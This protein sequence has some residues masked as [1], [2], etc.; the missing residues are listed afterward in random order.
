MWE[1]LN[2][3]TYGCKRID[4]EAYTRPD[5]EYSHHFHE[6]H[7]R[8]IDKIEQAI[9]ENILMKGINHLFILV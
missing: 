3:Y 1:Y 5:Q 6:D 4:S 2:E 9:E 8:S 7:W